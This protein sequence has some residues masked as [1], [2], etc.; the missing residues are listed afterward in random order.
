MRHL[1]IKATL[2]YDDKIVH[3]KDVDAI[4][5]FFETILKEKLTVHSNEIGDEIGEL[6]IT[7]VLETK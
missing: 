6:Q 4:I 3:G 5:W 1:K 2:S 7:E